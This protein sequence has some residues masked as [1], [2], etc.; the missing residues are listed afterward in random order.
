MA[1]AVDHHS[2]EEHPLNSTKYKPSKRFNLSGSEIS[3]R[4]SQ[5]IA[6]T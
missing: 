1:V 2:Y 4:K 5:T 6:V 3:R